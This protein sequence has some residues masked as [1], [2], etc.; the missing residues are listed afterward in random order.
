MHDS[1]FAVLKR[2]VP[3]MS[4]SMIRPPLHAIAQAYAYGGVLVNGRGQVLLRRP[5]DLLRGYA[6]TFPKG[7][8]EAG[9]TPAQTALREVREETGYDARILEPLPGAW[10]GTRG[11]SAFFLMEPLGE[12]G[13]FNEETARIVW[14]GFDEAAA[15]IAQSETTVGR[16]RDLGILAAARAV[17]TARCGEGNAAA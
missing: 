4:Q 5:A 2:P 13:A 17:W 12:P 10:R 3:L 1:A 16:V 14:L 6:W 8:P 9:E 15:L 7:S 11:T